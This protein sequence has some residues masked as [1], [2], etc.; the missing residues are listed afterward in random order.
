MRV[1][2]ERRIVC[3]NFSAIG[4]RTVAAL[5]VLFGLAPAGGP[6]FGQSF[7]PCGSN[8]CS[9]AGA[10]VGI[11]TTSPAGPLQVDSLVLNGSAVSNTN[12]A[13]LAIV[14]YPQSYGGAIDFQGP[15]TLL[16]NAVVM[17]WMNTGNNVKYQ[18]G[19]RNSTAPDYP[20]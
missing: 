20:N 13:D 15:N 1:K 4:T 9:S 14:P 10:N 11:G 17:N 3:L 8:I 2:P 16:D 12:S 7:S 19:L 5:I 18:W 6:L